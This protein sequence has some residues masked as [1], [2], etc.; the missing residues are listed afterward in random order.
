MASVKI[1]DILI[2]D[3]WNEYG[4]QMTT[5]KSAFWESGVVANVPG[6]VLPNGGSTVNMPFFND[7]TGDLETL[8]D[9]ASLTTDK[10]TTGKQKAVIIGRG[11]AW[12]S[13]DL[14]AVFAGADPARAILSKVAAFWQRK[15]QAELLSSVNGVFA[16][17]SMS[18]L[19]SDIS[20]NTTEA[21]RAFNGNTFIDATQLLG[22]NKSAVTAVAMHS[23]T[24]AYLAKQQLIVYEKQANGTDRVAYYMGKRV[25]IDDGLPATAGVYTTYIFGASVIGYA[26]AA[27]GKSDLET[28]RD[29][30]AGEDVFAM[31]KRFILHPIGMQ[32]TG[33]PLGDFPTRAELE[34][35]TNWNR[36]FEP[37]AIPMIAFKHTLA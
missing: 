16:S 14:A 35:G 10:I 23:A 27:V 15:M 28:D 19:V 36:V 17:A 22:D 33:T 32:F 37:K 25:I 1:S 34:T 20:A 31:R 5:E 9:N 21:T 6:I 24:E 26:T 11:K 3:V 4:E 7:L 29:I 30:L 13:N 8:D 12:S 18:G 2:P